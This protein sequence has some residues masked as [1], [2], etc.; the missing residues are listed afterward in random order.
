MSGL[1]QLV[2]W[3]TISTYAGIVRHPSILLVKCLMTSC[4]KHSTDGICGVVRVLLRLLPI[5]LPSRGCT[6]I[7]YRPPRR[8]LR[9]ASAIQPSW[10]VL[11]V[12]LSYQMLTPYSSLHTG[13]AAGAPVGG[14]VLSAAKGRWEIVACYSGSVQIVGACLLLYGNF[15]QLKFVCFRGSRLTRAVPTI[16]THIARF[17]RQPKIF[18]PY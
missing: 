3:S 10:Y 16:F 13:N 14:A 8:S 4:D 9:S 11:C 1:S 5:T 17:K 15:T 2:I 12:A 18:T 6:T 7:W